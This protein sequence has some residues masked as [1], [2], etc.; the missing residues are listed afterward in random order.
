MIVEVHVPLYNEDGTAPIP[1]QDIEIPGGRILG[2]ANQLHLADE[3]LF[4]T[5]LCHQST[6]YKAT[7]GVYFVR[8]GQQLPLRLDLALDYYDQA[9]YLGTVDRNHVFIGP[10]EGEPVGL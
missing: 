10:R 4:V 2:L 8:T 7:R 9:R 3:R 6:R 1:L 5:L